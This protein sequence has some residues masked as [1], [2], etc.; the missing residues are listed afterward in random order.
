MEYVAPG[1]G[2]GILGQALQTMV[3]GFGAFRSLASGILLAEGIGTRGPDGH[4]R[5]DPE[6]Y[7]ALEAE[8]KAFK[9]AYEQVGG[10]TMF[11][12]G[13][14][15]PENAIFPPDVVDVYASVES[16]N[17]AYHINHSK[18][19]VSMYDSATDRMIDGIGDYLTTSHRDQER[20]IVVNATPYPDDFS[21][22]IVTALARR[23]ESRANVEI[24][25]TKPTLKNGGETSTYIVTW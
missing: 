5:L 15:V 4:I 25:E 11:N 18:D 12:V 21:R 16:I 10:A 19:G 6:T 14:K 1:P 2:F 20:I 3:E 13:L 17:L 7:Y 23:F 8:L 9:H 24:D 22:G